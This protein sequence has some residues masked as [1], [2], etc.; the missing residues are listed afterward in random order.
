MRF[1]SPRSNSVE[2]LRS[3]FQEMARIVESHVG[4]VTQATAVQQGSLLSAGS[5][6]GGALPIVPGERGRS[7]DTGA[8]STIAIGSVT[9]GTGPSVVDVGTPYAAILDFVLPV[10]PTGVTGATGP[11]GSS[12]VTMVMLGNTFATNRAFRLVSGLAQPVY[13]TDAAMPDVDGI[14]LE[15]GVTGATVPAAMVV[16]SL[17]TTPLNLPAGSPL[18][19][20]QDGNPTATEPSSGAGDVWAVGTMRQDDSTHFIFTPTIPIKL[21]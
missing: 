8:T 20:G 16:G 5:G 6:G 18:F 12:A 3:A 14:I 19:L 17:Y 11:S 9:G 13:S 15:S 7:G 2:D 21:A 10:G 4:K 1:P